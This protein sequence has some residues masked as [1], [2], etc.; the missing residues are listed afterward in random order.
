MQPPPQDLPASIPRTEDLIL[1]LTSPQPAQGRLL[2][3]TLFYKHPKELLAQICDFLTN[4]KC[5]EH[6]QLASISLFSH[7]LRLYCQHFKSTNDIKSELVAVE[8]SVLRMIFK[9]CNVSYRIKKEL[10]NIVILLCRTTPG[11]EGHRWQQML[12]I[13]FREGIAERCTEQEQLLEFGFSLLSKVMRE[14]TDTDSNVESFYEHLRSGLPYA[15]AERSPL[16]V[17]FPH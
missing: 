8:R 15:L 13:I 2:L 4:E 3:E 14:L 7:F 16:A 17:R 11:D 1:L 5:E 6:Y 9:S 10:I 12:R